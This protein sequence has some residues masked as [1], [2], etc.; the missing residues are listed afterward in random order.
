MNQNIV[1]MENVRR[2]YSDN[3]EL[4][5]KYE[6]IVRSGKCPFC[7]PNIENTVVGETDH[8]I[9]V[10]NQPPYKTTR[11]H[12]LVLPR[13]HII[14]LSEMDAAEWANMVSAIGIATAEH[15]LLLDGYGLAVRAKEI[16]GV[17]L[18][19]LHWHL[20]APAIGENG[21]IAVN[22]GIG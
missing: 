17:T 4:V 22:F 3:A 9:I 12:L 21:Q 2:Y 8:W 18:Y 11:L 1:C 19:H 20:I 6:E 5:K 14:S 16:G 13:R 10:F 15:P 7:R